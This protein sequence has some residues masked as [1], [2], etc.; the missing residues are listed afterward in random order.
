[1]AAASCSSP[2]AETE[3]ARFSLSSWSMRRTRYCISVGTNLCC[4]V[5]PISIANMRSANDA[6]CEARASSAAVL[7]YDRMGSR[8]VGKF[9]SV[10]MRFLPEDVD[11]S[12]LQR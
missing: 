12:V 11:E 10:V 5:M 9:W 4:S 6:S 8:A 3:S 1:M 7:R 2:V